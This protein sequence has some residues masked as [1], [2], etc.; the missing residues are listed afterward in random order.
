MTD[1]ELTLRKNIL[2]NRGVS[3]YTNSGTPTEIKQ[4]IE[5]SCIDMINSILAYRCFG[6][7]AEQVMRS[8]ETSHYN[9][10]EDYVKKLGRERVVELIQGQINDIASIQYGVFEDDEGCTYNSI[11]WKEKGG[12]QA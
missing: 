5:L 6:F 10:L 1:K 8:E 12:A 2:H 7:T 4:S 11:V 3:H 9:Y